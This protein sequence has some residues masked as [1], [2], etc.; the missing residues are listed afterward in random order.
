MLGMTRA[1]Y[2]ESAWRHAQGKANR[3]LRHD[4]DRRGAVDS[5]EPDRTS[6]LSNSVEDRLVR[7][8]DDQPG[9]C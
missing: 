2:S 8:M 7:Q 5:Q 1:A 9:E 3:E 6:N 4:M